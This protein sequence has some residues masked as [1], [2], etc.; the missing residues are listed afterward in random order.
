M[1]IDLLRE[2]A[3]PELYRNNAFRLSGLPTEASARDIRRRTDEIRAAERLGAPLAGRPGLLAPDPEPE[4]QAVLDAMQHLRDPV[5]RVIEELF[6]FWPDAGDRPPLDP[7][8]AAR[9][10]LDRAKAGDDLAWHNLAVLTHARCLDFRPGVEAAS[11]REARWNDAYSY[12]RKVIEADG[13]WLALAARARS[14][15]DRRLTTG[16]VTELRAELPRALLSAQAT[17][18]VRAAESGDLK[19]AAWNADVVA[20]SAFEDHAGEVLAAAAAPLTARIRQACQRAEQAGPKVSATA[21]TVLLDETEPLLRMVLAILGGRDPRYIAAADQVG[22]A[23]NGCAARYANHTE[24]YRTSYDL[25][26]RALPIEVSPQTRRTLTD[27]LVTYIT[28]LTAVRLLAA[29]EKVEKRPDGQAAKVMTFAETLVPLL[30]GLREFDIEDDRRAP[31]WELLING[32]IQ[33]LNVYAAR[34]GDVVT[35]KAGLQRLL[36]LATDDSSVVADDLVEL[37]RGQLDV[38]EFAGLCWFCKQRTTGAGACPIKLSSMIDYS[39][40]TRL[41]WQVV[42]VD[43]PRC[44]SCRRSHEH[45]PATSVIG[46]PPTV[47]AVMI[48]VSGVV[49]ALLLSAVNGWLALLTLAVGLALFI[50]TRVIEARINRRTLTGSAAITIYSVSSYPPIAELLKEHWS[51]GER[52]P[53]I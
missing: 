29:I 25:V 27:N 32:S 52:P 45:P 49:G 42:T 35:A 12:W 1:A 7:E 17:A 9:H 26:R 18:A 21:G 28:N 51:I 53:G 23:V 40:V 2:V 20:E 6:W 47:A 39:E 3:T 11:V 15:D 50:Y 5:R 44:P 38:I 8:Q 31:V 33:L 37:V 14:L 10:W 4:P 48:I 34:T 22:L 43:V 19:S 30:A 16:F 41:T 13:P 36:T 24:G 46:L